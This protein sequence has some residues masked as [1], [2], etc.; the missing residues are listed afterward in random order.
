M[1]NQKYSAVVF[2]LG[3]VIL[4]FDYKLFVKKVNNHKDGIGER[5]LELYKSNYHIH[6]D[7]ER[8][9]IPEEVF[10]HQ[11]LKY[12]DNVIDGETFC[13]YWSDIFTLNED[14]AALLSVLKQKYKLYLVSNT[15]SI[16]K[17]YGFQHYE[18]LKLF[19]KLFLSHEVGY[20]KPE[21]EIYQAVEKESGFLP[22]EHIFID[23][24]WEYVEAA[25]Q[26]GWDGIQFNGYNDLVM[27]LKER[28]IL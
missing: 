23:D 21:K 5:F 1:T 12:L 4:S 9:K 26:L 3:Q 24:I 19:D 22:E 2:D 16:H 7:F 8:G 17:R 25:K 14:V 18:F 15:N 28:N 13:Q 20:V 10:I 27:N 6:R 11:M